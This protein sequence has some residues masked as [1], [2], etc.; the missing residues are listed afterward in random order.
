MPSSPV[1]GHRFLPDSTSHSDKGWGGGYRE[2]N[3]NFKTMSGR[4]QKTLRLKACLKSDL[5]QN[6]RQGAKVLGHQVE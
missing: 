6:F 3:L 5:F 2:R 1:I 4:K